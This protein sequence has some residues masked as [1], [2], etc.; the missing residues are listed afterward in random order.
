MR[1]MFSSSCSF[2]P[3]GDTYSFK[4]AI[5]LGEFKVDESAHTQ[6]RPR[7]KVNINNSIYIQTRCIERTV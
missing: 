6:D 7:D 2:T 1:E 3:Q 5:V 4:D